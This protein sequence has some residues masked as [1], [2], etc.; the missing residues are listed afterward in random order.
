[1]SL[2]ARHARLP[3]ALA[4]VIAVVCVLT[5]IAP[6]AGRTSWFLEVSPGL[7]YAGVLAAL[8]RRLP[9]SHFVYVG[10]FL[11]I[12]ILVYGG[13][14]TYAETPLGNWAKDTFDLSRNPYDRVGHLALG[15]FPAFTIREILLRETPLQRGGWL[16][17]LTLCV[18]LAMA[19]FWELL[20]W[21]VALLADPSV[22]TAFLGMQGDVWDTQWDMFLALVGAAVALPL[23][24][25]VHDRS[26]ARVPWRAVAVLV[27]LLV[28]APRVS[29]ADPI[30]ADRPGLATPAT[31]I[32]PGTAQI[33]TGAGFERESGH[34]HT[35][36]VGE[37]LLRIGVIDRAE[38][39]LDTVG[40]VHIDSDEEGSENAGGDLEVSTK[41]ELVEQS[42]WRPETSL[43]AG[44]SFP[45]GGRAVTSDGYDPFGSLLA[46]WQIG[47]RFDVDA[48]LGFADR[49]QGPD[50]SSR[51]FETFVAVAGDVSFAKRW[52]SF[53]EYF[54]TLRGS[55]AP[56]EHAVD[57]GFTYL[58]TDDVQL[59]VSA[60]AGL[61]DA[62]PDYFVD[63]GVAW[64]FWT[65]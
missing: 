55:G 10:I 37:P 9:L 14:Y 3:L 47:D 49:T 32:E 57:G 44:L 54:A 60:G 25:G 53:L 11:H 7:L 19:A 40:F 22:G 46:S 6:P 30:D 43:L 35:W 58:A 38:L 16:F 23:L 63:V 8:Y 18:V 20:E 28:A 13:V 65:P 24:S 31:V 2:L 61:S 45:T 34:E 41:I 62:A 4:A 51:V 1:V 48:N 56:D 12:L 21:W 33:E 5:L 52:G 50:D 39:R 27:A 29:H 26:M 36:T 17:F 42:S 64:R 15:I 59:D